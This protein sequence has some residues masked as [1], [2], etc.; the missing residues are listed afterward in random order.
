MDLEK[1]KQYLAI[2]DYDKDVVLR[3][4]ISDVEETIKNYCNTPEVPKGLLNTSYRMAMDLYRNENIGSEE[5]A[6][7]VSSITVGDTS[8]SF[9]ESADTEFKETLLKNYEPSLRRYRKVVFR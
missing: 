6:R 1:L 4:I 9:G 3:F 5:A 7:P 8:T 2:E